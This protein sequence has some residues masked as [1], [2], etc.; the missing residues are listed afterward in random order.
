MD[1]IRL[2]NHIQHYHWGTKSS[3]AVLLNQADLISEAPNAEYWIGAH[4]SLPSE[5][6]ETGEPLTNFL[7]SQNDE[8][9]PLPFLIKL[10]SADSPLSIQV[11]PNKTQAE[12]GFE[13][14]NQSGVEIDAMHRNY[15]DNNHKPE[16]IFALSPFEALAGFRS[17]TDILR[18]VIALDN[19]LLSRTIIGLST[20]PEPEFLKQMMQF[21]LTLPRTELTELLNDLLDKHTKK[22][23]P[24]LA[25]MKHLFTHYQYDPGVLMAL[26]LNKV[27]LQPGDSMF[28]SAGLP[29]AYLQ[30]TGIEVMATSDNVLRAGL[31]PKHVDIRELIRVATFHGQQPLVESCDFSVGTHTLTVPVPDYQIDIIIC[32]QSTD[33][34]QLNGKTEL[35]L[36]IQGEFTCNK[37]HIRQG[38][39][40]ILTK[41]YGK[42]DISGDGQLL[43]V[44]QSI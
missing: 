37:Q 40:F 25:T 36:I 3:I 32:K 23:L 15:K 22:L 9:A 21:L 1:L 26:M 11:H 14:E 33:T 35:L 31:T 5:I 7:S 2:K 27:E 42:F 18:D 38:E 4:P 8:A 20:L 44:Y 12:I 39:S 16:T 30:G 6:A 17:Q 41:T 10:L 28:L 24:T 43:R 13:R 29:H 19:E 34:I